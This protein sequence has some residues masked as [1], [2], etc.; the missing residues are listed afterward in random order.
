MSIELKPEVANTAPVAQRITPYDDT[1]VVTYLRLLDA[2]KQG[3]DWREVTRI[4]LRIDPSREPERAQRAFDSHLSRAK[5]L[6]EFG[7]KR[8]LRGEDLS[9]S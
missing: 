3:A 7:Y 4:V 2:N 6:T 1:H 5:W 9:G 8:M